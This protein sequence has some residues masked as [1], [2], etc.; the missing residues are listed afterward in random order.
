MGEEGWCP[1]EVLMLV[2]KS[3]GVAST[4]TPD[5]QLKQNACPQNIN[6]QTPYEESFIQ[7]Q[8]WKGNF[9]VIICLNN[10]DSHWF[11]CVPAVIQWARDNSAQQTYSNVY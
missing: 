9:N 4:K 2:R 11:S 1:E 6:I 8:A 3:K 7:I 10:L 5:N